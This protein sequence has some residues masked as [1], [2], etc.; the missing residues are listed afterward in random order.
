VFILLIYAILTAGPIIGQAQLIIGQT[1][2]NWETFLCLRH[3]C[4]R[5][6]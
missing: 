3:P 2:R 5:C 6:V 4:V 1:T